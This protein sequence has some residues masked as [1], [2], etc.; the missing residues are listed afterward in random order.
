MI[1][2]TDLDEKF[3]QLSLEPVTYAEK[4]KQTNKGRK[5]RYKLKIIPRFICAFIAD[6]LLFYINDNIVQFN[7]LSELQPFLTT[8]QNLLKLNSKDA[9]YNYNVVVWCKDTNKILE[10]LKPVLYVEENSIKERYNKVAQ[11]QNA[12]LPI[13]ITLNSMP[14]WVISGGIFATVFPS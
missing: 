4:R 13:L 10:V 5:K 1:N 7:D 14:R 12:H 6:P 3:S 8:L 11:F 9:E 2:Y